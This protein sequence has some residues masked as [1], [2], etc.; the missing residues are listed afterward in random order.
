MWDDTDMLL[1]YS[2]RFV[3]TGRGAMVGSA[4]QSTVK[5]IWRACNYVLNEQGDEIP[6]FAR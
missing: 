6:D 4:V 3:V 2:S 5:T 1:Q